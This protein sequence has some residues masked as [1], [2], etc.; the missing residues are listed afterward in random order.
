MTTKSGIDQIKQA[1]STLSKSVEEADTKLPD[2][3][4]DLMARH[5]DCAV[6]MTL[7]DI[8]NVE[9]LEAIDTVKGVFVEGA[10]AYPN[11]GFMKETHIQ[12]CVCNPECIRGVFR[13]PRS[14]LR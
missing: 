1:Y 4:T 8:R 13:V 9:G 2:N 6:I 3:G 5:L 14:D 10:E 12:I 11:S 7:H